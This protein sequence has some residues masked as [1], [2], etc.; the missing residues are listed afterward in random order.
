MS[1]CRPLIP[2]GVL[3]YDNRPVAADIDNLLEQFTNPIL[4]YDQKQIRLNTVLINSLLFSLQQSDRNA[5]IEAAAAGSTTIPTSVFSDYPA[6]QDRFEQGSITEEEFSDFLADRGLTPDYVETVLTEEYPSDINIDAINEAINEVTDAINETIQQILND[7]ATS[8]LPLPNEDDVTQSAGDGELDQFE[9]NVP[10]VD[11]LEWTPTEGM[12]N[13]LTEMDRYYSENYGALLAKSN[14]CAALTNPF[15]K[16]SSLIASASAL[17]TGLAGAVAG[18]L[19][20]AAQ[21]QSKISGLVN[22]IQNFS[23][24]S[25]VSSLAGRLANL[26]NEVLGILDSALADA[27]ARLANLKNTAMQLFQDIKGLPVAAHRMIT[28]KLAQIENFLSD[29]NLERI[30]SKIKSI[31]TVNEDQF[32]DLLPAVLTILALKACAIGNFLDAIM[33][34]PLDDFNDFL[35]LMQINFNIMENLSIIKLNRV[36]DAGGLR[37]GREERQTIRERSAETANRNAQPRVEAEGVDAVPG[38]PNPG[39]TPSR[40]IVRDLNDQEARFVAE[41][42]A[43]Y[44]DLFEFSPSVKNMGTRARSVYESGGGSYGP[45]HWR[46]WD[47]GENGPDAGWQMII[48]R[49]PYIYVGLARVARRLRQDGLLNAPLY[50][51]SAFRSRYYNRV[52]L[53]NNR[54]VAQ[55]SMHMNAMALDIDDTVSGLNSEGTARFIDYMSEEGFTRFGVYAGFI[56]VDI[57][58]GGTVPV[59]RND[60]TGDRNILAALNNHRARAS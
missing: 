60:R 47:E 44:S 19:D 3:K 57:T 15:T 32:E 51:T 50:I 29:L 28:K 55:N 7:N 21:L 30:K 43:D 27:Q 49:H 36:I 41:I 39:L 18:A 37:V 26:K 56:H 35:G 25:L 45:N 16:L 22:S 58:E 12:N 6:L 38:Q 1:V 52:V 13:V 24:S 40:H 33:R 10:V 59:F 2:T 46:E 17:A 54:G 34:K 31:L 23:L 8:T 48:E 14:A 5:A 20:F 9:S 4:R 11:L 53:H 42:T